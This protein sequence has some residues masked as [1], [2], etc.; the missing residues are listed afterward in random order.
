MIRVGHA[1]PPPS[2][3]VDSVPAGLI[4]CRGLEASQIQKLT[5]RP[6]ATAAGEG[7]RPAPFLVRSEVLPVG[8]V[9]HVL[10]HRRAWRQLGWIQECCVEVIV[11]V[12]RTIYQS[13]AFERAS[14]ILRI[15]ETN[16]R[17]SIAQS[18]PAPIFDV[19]Q[20]IVHSTVGSEISSVPAGCGKLM[21]FPPAIA[22][23]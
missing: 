10:Q 22:S 16:E 7:A 11:P 17:A 12:G 8:Q 21:F 9:D 6:T 20:E 14:G 19:A 13:A 4:C 2:P 18:S 15:I 5:T 23:R 3:E 1:P